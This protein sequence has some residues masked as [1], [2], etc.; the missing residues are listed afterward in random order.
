M[1]KEFSPEER[2]LRLIKGKQ[3]KLPDDNL[4]IPRKEPDNVIYQPGRQ[5]DA[6]P[7]E[8]TGAKKDAGTDK[9]EPVKTPAD[10][11]KHKI[12]GIAKKTAKG[13][14]I[15]YLMSGVFIILIFTAGYVVFNGLIAKEDKEV[16]DLK[17]LIESFSEAEKAQDTQ[18]GRGEKPVKKKE[19]AV[20]TTKE[21]A[22]SFD[23]YRKLLSQK[24][25]FAPPAKSSTRGKAKPASEL[26]EMAKDLSL[27]GIIPGNEPQAIIEDRRNSQTLFLKKGETIDAIT[28]K[29]ISNGKVI[30]EYNDQTITISL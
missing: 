2:L 12:A 5:E 9:R 28:I 10:D 18:D 14:N 11:W 8:I 13:L 1:S 23:D 25:I 26:R 30:L 24:S 20:T 15:K 19:P 17:L 21:E 6:G 3:G 4:H 29:D 27:V 7:A 16:E 22:D